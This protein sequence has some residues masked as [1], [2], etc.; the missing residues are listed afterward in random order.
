MQ[1]GTV[2]Q[3][4]DVWEEKGVIIGTENGNPVIMATTGISYYYDQ[5]V[6]EIVKDAGIEDKLDSRMNSTDQ[7]MKTFVDMLVQN[8]IETVS[9][10]VKQ[11][12]QDIHQIR[13]TVEQRM[14]DYKNVLTQLNAKKQ[15]ISMI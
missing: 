7:S 11:Q 13:L 1:I 10:T 15:T 2:V 14:A 9:K 5:K 8:E 4:R 6:W 12:N 3:S